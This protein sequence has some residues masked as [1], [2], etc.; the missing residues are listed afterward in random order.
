MVEAAEE[1]KKCS[2]CERLIEASKIRLHEMGC[3]RMN[4]KCRECGEVVAK[5]DKEE[6]DAEAHVPIKCQYCAFEAQKSK[7][8]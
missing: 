1:T 5:E 8:G 6:H 4:Y 3:A 7:F 2:T